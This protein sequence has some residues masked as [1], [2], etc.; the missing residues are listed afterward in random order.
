MT[1]L[2]RLLNFLE[3]ERERRE[4]LRSLRL[5]ERWHFI[6]KRQDAAW[7]KADHRNALVDD[8]AKRRERA[9]GFL[10]RLI[11]GA[12]RQKGAAA[13]EW[14]LCAIRRLGDLHRVARG[15][16]HGERGVKIFAFEIA[17]EGIGEEN[18]GAGL[19]V[20]CT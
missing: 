18:D 12:D 1:G 9:L 13:A 15:C 19:R 14:A 4:L 17:I 11:D 16:Q 7:L 5:D 20:A 6:A 10:P 3:G 2:D 8:R